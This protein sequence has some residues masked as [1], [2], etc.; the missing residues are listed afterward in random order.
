M[1]EYLDAH[2]EDQSRIMDDNKHLMGED[3]NLGAVSA[4]WF[5][6]QYDT[7]S[8]RKPKLGRM[9]DHVWSRREQ[10]TVRNKLVQVMEGVEPARCI[11]KLLPF[12]DRLGDR[13]SRGDR[14]ISK[15]EFVECLD[16]AMVKKKQQTKNSYQQYFKRLQE[17]KT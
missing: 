5:F 8:R 1:A 4:A 15:Q 2:P 13:N 11:R 16:P 7:D 9:K 10:S 3:N 17:K 14:K 6:S 12:C